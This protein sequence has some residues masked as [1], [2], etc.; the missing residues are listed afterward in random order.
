MVADIHSGGF[1]VFLNNT[2]ESSFKCQLDKF[3]VGSC[4]LFMLCDGLLS[5]GTV[6]LCM[7][8]NC[9]SLCVL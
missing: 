9:A 5:V 3:V 1:V 6:P 4:V 8:L 2:S 7:F